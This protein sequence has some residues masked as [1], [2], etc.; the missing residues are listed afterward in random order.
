MS[1]FKE[2]IHRWVFGILLSAI[3]LT[4]LSANV[5]GDEAV[6]PSEEMQVD[7]AF[8]DKSEE[9]DAF[10]A[11]VSK[12][13]YTVNAGVPVSARVNGRD[14][15][16]DTATVM[17]DGLVENRTDGEPVYITVNPANSMAIESVSCQVSSSGSLINLESVNNNTFEI[18]QETVLSATDK[19][20]DIIVLVHLINK[21]DNC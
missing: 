6:V 2:S 15:S 18:P 8:E 16:A 9:N 7:C 12:E 17:F 21:E 11:V 4:A 3:V 1:K 19:Q 14:P 5:F 20:N 13:K 10:K